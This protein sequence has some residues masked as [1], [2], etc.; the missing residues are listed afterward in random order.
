[1]APRPEIQKPVSCIPEHRVIESAHRMH[2]DAVSFRKQ[3]RDNN[4]DKP[5]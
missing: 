2:E 5:L 4:H 1:M 3:L